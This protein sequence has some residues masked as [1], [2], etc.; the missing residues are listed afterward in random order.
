MKEIG[1]KLSLEQIKSIELD[2]LL[3]FANYCEAHGL[4]YY[5]AYGTL[6][7]AVRHKGFIPWDDD[8]DVVMLRDDY[9]RLNDLLTRDKIRE[10]LEW[11]SL[12]NGKW[13]EPYGKLINVNTLLT[14]ERVKTSIWIDLFPL[15]YYD[16][17]VLKENVFM[18]RVHL[19]KN[20]NHFSLDKKG[21]AKFFL[22]GLFFWKSFMNISMGI[23][24]RSIAIKPN[25]KIAHMVWAG[26]ETDFYDKSMFESQSEVMFEGYLF[27]SVADVDGYLKQSFGNYMEFPP[28]S[29]RKGHGMTA[30]WI[31]EKKCPF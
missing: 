14:V 1:Q 16:K 3:A 26:D 28:I 12:Q 18:R 4:K 2:I 9:M 10:D 25:S 17:M 21:I 23:E 31:S 8:I 13:N 5:L 27:K 15:D 30:Y 6:L 29:E 7:G 24:K 20:T 19:S 11:V 22:R